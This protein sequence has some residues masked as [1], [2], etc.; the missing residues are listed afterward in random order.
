MAEQQVEELKRDLERARQQLAKQQASLE[1]EYAGKLAKVEHKV[2][3]E[4]RRLRKHDETRAERLE[5]IRERMTRAEKSNRL[6]EEHLMAI[7][8]KL[9]ILEGAINVLDQRLRTIRQP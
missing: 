1:K 2:E 7:E 9:D 4:A 8:V 6:G 5:E 3:Q